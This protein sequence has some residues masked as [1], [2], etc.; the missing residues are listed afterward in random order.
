MAK[1]GE[2]DKAQVE[3]KAYGKSKN[4]PEAAELV[5]VGKLDALIPGELD[6]PCVCGERVCT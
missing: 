2:F 1:E 5:S 4:D 6:H 3:L